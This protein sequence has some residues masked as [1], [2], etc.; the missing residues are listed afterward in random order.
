MYLKL[1]PSRLIFSFLILPLVCAAA[2]GSSDDAF[3][4]VASI[5]P[6][7]GPL[8]GGNTVV[9]TGEG[10]TL[11]GVNV[12]N[13]LVGDTLV[14]GTSVLSDTE[15][16]ITIPASLEPGPVDVTLFNG[17][18]NVVIES[19][20]SYN[21]QP[22]VTAVAPPIGPSAGGQEVT[23][24]GTGFASLEPGDNAVFIGDSQATV[25]EVLSDTELVVTTPLGL[26]P[27]LLPVR[28]ENDN[29]AST[30]EASYRYQ[31][32]N[33]LLAFGHGQFPR[34]A[35][36]GQILSVD[37]ETLTVGVAA[38]GSGREIS[39]FQGEGVSVAVLFQNEI[40]YKSTSQIMFRITPSGEHVRLGNVLGCVSGKVHAMTVHRGE[41]FALCRE[42]SNG[43][44]GGKGGGGGNSDFGTIDL[45][46]LT[47][48]PIG[49]VDECCQLNL[50]SDG[51]TLFFLRNRDLF[52]IDAEDGTLEFVAETSLARVR[53]MVFH[54]GSLYALNRGFSG[55]G[56]GG[57]SPSFLYR[58]NPD[59]GSSEVLT[60]LGTSLHGLTQVPQ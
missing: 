20:Y 11:G 51:E 14:S 12:N 17:N 5:T 8:V 59:D 9:V 48:S 54:Q 1:A 47:F 31:T 39:P 56:G 21:P 7:N 42:N 60:D 16:H 32:N 18:G 3:V 28:V 58:I 43:G 27:I 2:C 26:P 25:S 41:I 29:G 33:G 44:G 24:T 45:E 40:I 35:E 34:I 55:G 46:T 13:V 23:L 37:L 57:G 52:R 36:A 4:E 50:A 19:A 38:E 53:G 10:F 22:T 30:L 49:A 15:I 6:G